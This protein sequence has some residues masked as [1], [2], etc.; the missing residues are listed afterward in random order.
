MSKS[1]KRYAEKYCD[2]CGAIY[3]IPEMHKTTRKHDGSN[4]KY[5]AFVCKECQ[6]EHDKTARAG[7]RVL[8]WAFAGFLVFGAWAS[9][10]GGRLL[11]PLICLVIAFLIARSLYRSRSRA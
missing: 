3:P 7:G 6:A 9:F 5:T 1:K 4:H 11:E 8:G 2:D 10:M